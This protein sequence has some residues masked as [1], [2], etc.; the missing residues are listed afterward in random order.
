MLRVHSGLSQLELGPGVHLNATSCSIFVKVSLVDAV[1]TDD[2][3]A[4]ALSHELGHFIADHRRR[5]MILEHAIPPPILTVDYWHIDTCI[6][7]VDSMMVCPFRDSFTERADI[8][9][10][11]S[12]P[13]HVTVP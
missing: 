11:I 13:L 5:K 1:N 7:R 10:P 4:A 12:S 9:R 6:E 8:L 3:L 2:E